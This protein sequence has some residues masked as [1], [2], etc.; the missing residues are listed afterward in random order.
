MRLLIVED[1]AGMRNKLRELL[2]GPNVEMHECGTGE[3]AMWSVHDF[4]PDW[5]IMDVNLPGVNGFEATEAIR[6]ELP[7]VRV[8]IICAEDRDYLRIQAQAV[9]AE[10]FLSKHHLAKLPGILWGEPPQPPVV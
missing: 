7:S 2:A 9:G 5:I 4:Q 10:Q 8:V 6:K 1:H 3:E